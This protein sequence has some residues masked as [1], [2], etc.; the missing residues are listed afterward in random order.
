MDSE[1]Q[2]QSHLI[3]YF[4]YGYYL[5]INVTF[6]H[7]SA[8]LAASRIDQRA[9]CAGLEGAGRTGRK[10]PPLLRSRT[11]PAIV[12]PGV[13]ILQAQLGSYSPDIQQSAPS[14]PG[15]SSRFLSARVSF[16]RDDTVALDM[17]RKSAVSRL[18]GSGNYGPER[19]ADGTLLLRVPA[20]HVVAARAYRISSP[21]S[22]S[23][24]LYRLG[25]LLNQ[26]G[27]KNQVVVDD[28]NVP[29]RLSWERF[30]LLT[31]V[32]CVQT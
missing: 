11:L 27:S 2:K 24:A 5:F 20:P 14:R 25:K 30:V 17:R 7:F 18:C 12:V 13:N 29:R 1:P 6:F 15:F 32:W 28:S 22:S 9:S 26:G 21:S 3:L 31:V 10:P 8:Q 19:G 16:S 4:N 23:T